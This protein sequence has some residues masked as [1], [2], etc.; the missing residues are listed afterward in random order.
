MPLQH[1]PIVQRMRTPFVDTA[2][3]HLTWRD[4]PAL[5]KA[6]GVSSTAKSEFLTRPEL[7]KRNKKYI[8]DAPFVTISDA[9]R[10]PLKNTQARPNFV[11]TI[12]NGIPRDLYQVGGKGVFKKNLKKPDVFLK[13]QR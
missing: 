8:K 12:Y 4:L 6:F 11:A 1:L 13:V 7:I 2:H 9:Q 3:G 5:F 10:D